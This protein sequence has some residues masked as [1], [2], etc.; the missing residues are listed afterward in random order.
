M[1]KWKGC[2]RKRAWPAIPRDAEFNDKNR[3][4]EVTGPKFNRR[5]GLQMFVN[6]ASEVSELIVIL[7]GL[8]QILA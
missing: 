1:V 5:I 8:F 3:R 6:S 7:V 2:R 4:T